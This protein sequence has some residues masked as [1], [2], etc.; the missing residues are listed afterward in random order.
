[1]LYY[2]TPLC[3][4]G[5]QH[6]VTKLSLVYIQHTKVLILCPQSIKNEHKCID[7]S[8][9]KLNEAMKRQVQQFIY[10]TSRRAF[11]HKY[12]FDLCVFVERLTKAG[13]CHVQ[14]YGFWIDE[15]GV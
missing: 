12:L 7:F 15:A 10:S 11:I 14:E 9:S 13:Y 6:N 8:N 2:K 5:K 1:M 3:G 4:V